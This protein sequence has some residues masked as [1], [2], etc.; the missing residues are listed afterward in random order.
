MTDSPVLTIEPLPPCLTNPALITLLLALPAARLVGG[1]VRDTLL[2]RAVA[3]IDLASPLPPDAVIAT[4]REAGIR[5]VPTG[6]DHGT[7]T[8]VIDGHGFEI[9][10]LRRDV[11]TDGR[12]AIVAFTTDWRTDASRRDFT[13]N[14]MSMTR[15]GAVYDYFGGVDDLHAGIVRF[16]GDA[17]TRIAEDYLRILR[18]FRFFARYGRT[19]PDKATLS[20][21]TAG[22]H[23]LHRLSAER[24]W[25]ELAKILS[26]PDPRRAIALMASTRAL[27]AVV[28]EG[29][30][31]A[32]LIRLI[33][34]GAP[35]DAI[36]RMAALLIGDPT[37]FAER[38]KL[39][40]S[41]RDRLLALR[42]T[43]LPTPDADD[44]TLR[45][46][47]AD[48]DAGLLVD[49]AWLGGGVS[50]DWAGLRVRIAAMPRPVFPL[51]GR[52]VVAAGQPPGPGVGS[53]LRHVRDWWMERG[54]VDD[55]TSCRDEL[56]R[57]LLAC[58]TNRRND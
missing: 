8:A 4:L 14:A 31:P 29:A 17:A 26:T 13:I 36:L 45:R 46:A 10:T 28:P 35:I 30:D 15:D 22:V 16:V 20:A 38:L 44:A 40:G 56:H 52:D 55:L 49:R 24:V 1:V 33:D 12:H 32:R 41:D 18:F 39:S 3:D 51:S 11:E 42:N 9:T 53:I 27:E 6:M 23:G 21:L 2:G 57:C 54:C 43:P 48:W 47:L 19:E 34:D 5:V 7:V 37:V 25:S 58:D 50:A